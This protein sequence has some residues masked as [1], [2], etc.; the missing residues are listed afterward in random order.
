LAPCIT[1]SVRLFLASYV[2]SAKSQLTQDLLTKEA[3]DA[4]FTDTQIS[5]GLLQATTYRR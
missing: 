1:T 5:G 3:Q 4:G 2:R